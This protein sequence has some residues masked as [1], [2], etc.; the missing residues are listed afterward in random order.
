MSGVERSQTSVEVSV[1][2][3]K[4]RR[5]MFDKPAGLRGPAVPTPAGIA[6]GGKAPSSKSRM[7]TFSSTTSPPPPLPFKKPAPLDLRDSRS[8]KSSSLPADAATGR[9]AASPAEITTTSTA[10]GVS[11]DA[12]VLRSCACT[13][14]GTSAGGTSESAAKAPGFAAD[15]APASVFE[16]LGLCSRDCATK[17][18]RHR[19]KPL[20]DRMCPVCPGRLCMECATE[21]TAARPDHRLEKISVLAKDA[22]GRVQAVV[23]KSSGRSGSRFDDLA[24]VSPPIVAS[25]RRAVAYMDARGAL[26]GSAVL[27]R[28]HLEK[29]HE[30]V[31]RS[32][33]F[34][35]RDDVVTQILEGRYQELLAALDAAYATKNAKLETWS[36]DADAV[37]EASLTT[38]AALAEAIETLDD[39]EIAEHARTLI[40]RSDAMQSAVAALPSM[41]TD[42]AFVGYVRGTDAAV[43][44][45]AA[46]S[47]APTDVLLHLAM[48]ALGMIVLAPPR[49]SHSSVAR[50]RLLTLVGFDRTIAKKLT[51][52]VRGDARATTDD[53][54]RYAPDAEVSDI[55]KLARSKVE[56]IVAALSALSVQDVAK[57]LQICAN[58]DAVLAC[59]EPVAH[60]EIH[61]AVHSHF[62]KL[63]DSLSAVISTKRDALQISL[64][65]SNTALNAM[66]MIVTELVEV[67][68]ETSDE[69]VAAETSDV[70]A[71][72]E[73]A[74]AAVEA[75]VPS[76][77]SAATFVGASNPTAAALLSLKEF[78]SIADASSE[79]LVEAVRR[80]SGHIFSDTLAIPLPFVS[81]YDMRKRLIGILE[82]N[83]SC[84]GASLSPGTCPASR[85][86]AAAEAAGVVQEA[87]H[88]ALSYAAALET[89]AVC[90]ETA[91]QQLS[92]NRSAILALF[93]PD[94]GGVGAD[95]VSEPAMTAASVLLD[96]SS[97]PLDASSLLEEGLEECQRQFDALLEAF[98]TASAAKHVELERLGVIADDAIERA[99]AA[100]EEIA[101]TTAEFDDFD[102]LKHFA[103]LHLRA[104]EVRTMVDALPDLRPAH[105]FISFSDVPAVALRVLKGVLTSRSHV[106][107]HD[108]VSRAY[109]RLHLDD[110][111][112]PTISTSAS[113]RALLR[114]ADINPTQTVGT[115]MP[116]AESSSIIQAARRKT[117]EVADAISTLN[118]RAA[119]AQKLLKG[120]L[121]F[122]SAQLVQGAS[123]TF[124]DTSLRARYESCS[125]SL[126]AGVASKR[127]E[128]QALSASC[129]AALQSAL[130]A[131]TDLWL[132]A[133]EYDDTDVDALSPNAI[134]KAEAARDAVHALPGLSSAS[135][136]VGVSTPPADSLEQLRQLS[137]G[138]PPELPTCE[139]VVQAL[140]SV[141]VEP[142]AVW[143]TRSSLLASVGIR[144]N[145]PPCVPLGGVFDV[146][147]VDASEVLH[148]AHGKHLAFTR[149]LELF[150]NHRAAA[151]GQLE[152]NRRNVLSCLSA[153]RDGLHVHREDGGSSGGDSLP[154]TDLHQETTG[155]HA[156]D[157]LLLADVE[158]FFGVL[159]G[160]LHSISSL[161][162]AA[163]GALTSRAREAT[164]M[165]RAVASE[166]VIAVTSYDDS[167]FL[168]RAAAL[169]DRGH[170]ARATVA[171]IP[172]PSPEEAFLVVTRP[173]ATA[174]SD[175][176]AVL[177]MAST[178]PKQ[179]LQAIDRAAG[180]L[181]AVPIGGN[182]CKKDA[183]RTLIFAGDI[184]GLEAMLD[185][186]AA[187]EESDSSGETALLLA[188]RLGHAD[189]VKELLH[190][191][192]AV[193]ARDCLSRT[194]LYF[195]ALYDKAEV[196][197]LLLQSPRV[198]VN[199]FGPWGF[200]ALKRAQMCGH[201]DVASLLEAAS[202]TTR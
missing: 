9:P 187:L 133:T 83:E 100:T 10:A 118:S 46:L 129:N 11:Q 34:L 92:V 53:F 128:L 117:K 194:A 81:V 30:A 64:N 87:K 183:L 107:M 35:G 193:N 123:A 77:S 184:V 47:T 86:T 79:R 147:G 180:R 58:R 75:L 202:R 151:F 45:L 159:A 106:A 141:L 143:A 23:G 82:V 71:R 62:A 102:I 90:T 14:S 110:V 126:L 40:A 148:S 131:V 103:T 153:P 163:L 65:A 146:P 20:A 12:F 156:E 188:S 98:E 27:A 198:D 95:S 201:Y 154:A 132:I 56:S 4:D 113:R 158:E 5:A 48:R 145:V 127:D 173:R 130:C 137:M 172:V 2:S 51:E 119:A 109:G 28:L 136:F 152:S 157:P 175:L 13:F 166:I 39:A 85:F 165:T 168:A 54:L 125:A 96:A 135:A 105:T 122:A 94:S 195:A 167:A 80:A 197:A 121:E 38:V 72:A 150:E 138:P 164:E 200:T 24:E 88:K 41:T 108:A 114:L 18:T 191:G 6:P 31:M 70:T 52:N 91:R 29:F 101:E 43:R 155:T 124:L 44:A 15:D 57:R 37:L 116:G 59:I 16:R 93:A 189:M 199:S 66:V 139:A 89:L 97:V 55:V 144:E 42:A 69:V 17:C 174:L 68:T 111:P 171:A 84:L 177:A 19:G 21:H 22:R 176:K 170:S 60:K 196:A 36:N 50:I 186:G 179:R 142:T 134:A 162:N 1:G 3:F 104:K 182:G 140:G 76:P 73:A 120:N 99:L 49:F 78:A 178:S 185:M 32:E 63:L 26:E 74:R 192:A 160:S 190:A 161:K 169:S 115:D 61:A 149:A 7:M 181:F 33:L 112:Q 25:R 8:G 67:A